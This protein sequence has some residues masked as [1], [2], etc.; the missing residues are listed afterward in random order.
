MKTALL[1]LVISTAVRADSACMRDAERF[2]SRIPIGEGR[3]LT[4]LQSR[5]SE[6]SSS[7]QQD[8]QEINNKSREID[9]ACAS[10]V[11]QYCHGVA[12]GADRIKVC[13]WSNW[14]RLSSTCRDK[15]A[16]IS[17]KREKLQQLCP[18][19]IQNLCPGVNPGGGRIYL[20]LKAQES[21]VSFQC[22][23]ALN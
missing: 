6:L 21:K 19:D 9:Q 18:A 7:C 11:Y 23:P 8:L 5:W 3:M 2:C 15:A 16:E 17:E 4:C 1:L 20:C 12:P 10:D 14:D 22:R 13:L